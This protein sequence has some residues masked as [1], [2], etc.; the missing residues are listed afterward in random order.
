MVARPLVLVVTTVEKLAP[1]LDR[2]SMAVAMADSATSSSASESMVMVMVSFDASYAA[3]VAAPLDVA[4]SIFISL[5]SGPDVSEVTFNVLE[6]M[7]VVATEAPDVSNVPSVTVTAAKFVKLLI[8]ATISVAL[9]PPES[10]S[11]VICNS[12]PETVTASVFP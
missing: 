6:T 2:L 10:S 8:A 4:I 12:S 9:E 3:A 1:S 7:S 5:K 11:S